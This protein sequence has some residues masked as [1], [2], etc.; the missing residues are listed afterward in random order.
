MEQHTHTKNQGK[1][2]DLSQKM[3]EG[4]EKK[5]TNIFYI[6]VLQLVLHTKTINTH[7]DNK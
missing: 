6:L 4:L 7:T 5:N 3:S 2:V 1:R